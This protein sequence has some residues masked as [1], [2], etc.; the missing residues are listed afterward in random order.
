MRIF[1]TG[2]SGY[3]GSVLADQLAK[4]PEVEFITGID[5][6]APKDPLPEK[7]R[8]QQMDIRSPELSEAV[9]GHDTIIHTAFIV[10]WPARIPES[11][12]DDINLNG[13]RNVA[14]AGVSNRVGRFIHTSSIAVYDPTLVADKINVTE[15]FPLCKGNSFFY[16]SNGKGLAESSLVEVLGPSSV[17]LTILRPAYIIGPMNRDTISSWRQTLVKIPGRVAYFQFIH[18]DDLFAAFCKAIQ[19]DMPGAYNVVADDYITLSDV[20]QIIGMKRVPVIPIWL[21]HWVTAIRWKYF[22]SLVHSSWV[23]AT[24][25][26]CSF[27]NSKLKATGWQPRYSSRAALASALARPKNK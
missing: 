9:A 13:I 27:S 5:I 25:S 7:V 10:L 19:S 2:V 22:G 24:Y 18:E 4:L 1:L 3:L 8:F 6:S 26:S 21:A 11:V 15:D 23:D 14:Q 16:Y 17:T 12:R 20:A